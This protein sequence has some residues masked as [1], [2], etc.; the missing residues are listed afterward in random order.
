MT[1]IMPAIVVNGF[2]SPECNDACS[3]QK[4]PSLSAGVAYDLQ[5]SLSS[6]EGE[7]VGYELRPVIQN[8]VTL[9]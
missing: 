5:S 2:W 6:T 8:R 3:G 7:A 4:R 1:R 9:G